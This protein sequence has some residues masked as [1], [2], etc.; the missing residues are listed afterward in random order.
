MSICT[1]TP[2]KE[3]NKGEKCESC[4]NK[5]TQFGFYKDCHINRL[6]SEKKYWMNHFKETLIKVMKKMKDE[7]QKH[8]FLKMY[9]KHWEKE[10]KQGFLNKSELENMEKLKRPFI[11]AEYNLIPKDLI[12]V[13]DELMLNQEYHK[14][15]WSTAK[16]F[17][18]HKGKKKLPDL[19]YDPLNYFR[20]VQNIKRSNWDD[21]YNYNIIRTGGGK[22]KLKKPKE[23]KKR[24]LTKKNRK[25]NRKVKI[26]KLKQDIDF[27][28]QSN[29]IYPNMTANDLIAFNDKIFARH[30]NLHS[31]GDFQKKSRPIPNFAPV[32]EAIELEMSRRKKK[33]KPKQNSKIHRKLFGGKKSK[34]RRRKR[35]RKTTR[36]KR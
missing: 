10:Q 20:T 36:K 3:I 30:D 6:T 16:S 27:I 11:P 15:A 29:N 23:A 8:E 7:K 21:L 22:K 18:S 32:E 13:I 35:R 33:P 24:I 14:S 17:L 26:D 12:D 4:Y 34:R 5:N 1:I 31:P 28:L 9:K 25:N 2:Q 19:N